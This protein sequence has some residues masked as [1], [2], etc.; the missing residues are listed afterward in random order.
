MPADIGDVRSAAEETVS[1]GEL[2]DDLLWG[3]P[4]SGHRARPPCFILKHRTR[5][6]C[7]SV[8]GGHLRGDGVAIRAV[9]R[10]LIEE[11]IADQTRRVLGRVPRPHTGATEIFDLMG[12]VRAMRRLS[13]R[14]VPRE[15]LEALIRS[16]SWGPTGANRQ[17]FSFVVVTEKER[18]S[19]IA[20]AWYAASSFY[21]DALAKGSSGGDAAFAA[22]TK[23]MRYQRDHIAETPALI[24]ACYQS[25]R[26]SRRLLSNPRRAAKAF[27]A[28]GLHRSLSMTIRHRRW[29]TLAAA[30]SLLPAVQN[31]LLS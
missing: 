17:A 10:T 14:S 26:F 2:S 16:A 21:L 7:G 5:T 13:P 11:G 3:V 30:A 19:R 4:A 6:A 24:F 12:T 9:Y 15:H 25:S 28:L 29:A 23:A 31:L 8:F 18:V 22:R 20:D 1:L 27:G